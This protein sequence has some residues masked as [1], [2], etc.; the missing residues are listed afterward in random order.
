M[1]G[2]GI[3]E[4]SQSNHHLANG[5]IYLVDY[6]TDSWNLSAVWSHK[7]KVKTRAIKIKVKITSNEKKVLKCQP[8]G[9]IPHFSKQS[10][11]EP[12][13]W[14]Y[15]N[16]EG[17]VTP[18]VKDPSQTICRF[19]ADLSLREKVALQDLEWSQNQRCEMWFGTRFSTIINALNFSY[20][21]VNNLNA[22]LGQFPEYF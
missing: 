14:S 8:K 2:G 7:I 6:I 18:G 10:I 15:K 22:R 20:I 16:L 19:N 12:R 11:L 17:W 9:I 5:Y 1:G 13:A 4:D 3:H 21:H